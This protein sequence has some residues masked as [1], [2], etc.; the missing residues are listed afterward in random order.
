MPSLI[1]II[2]LILILALLL[3]DG[4]IVA[5]APF[6]ALSSGY[7]HHHLASAHEGTGKHSTQEL[8]CEA[9]F[10]IELY[11]KTKLSFELLPLNYCGHSTANGSDQVIFGRP[12]PETAML[13]SFMFQ[14]L[15]HGN[16]FYTSH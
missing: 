13:D 11:D 3:C 8:E 7:V 9:H 14:S 15:V 2:I 10:N 5:M 4:L 6:Q 1:S 16:T 12:W